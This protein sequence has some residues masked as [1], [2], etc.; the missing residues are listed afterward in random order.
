MNM[1]IGGLEL[2]E[3]DDL[4]EI[5]NKLMEAKRMPANA[6]YFA[7]TATPKSRTEELFGVEI[8][9]GSDHESA[10]PEKTVYRPFDSYTMKQAIQEGFIKD[11]LKN[12]TPVESYYKLIKSVDDDPLFDTEKAQKKLRRYVEGHERSIRAKAEVMLEHFDRQVYRRRLIGGDAR[13]MVVTDGVNRALEY[14]KA[15]NALI[16]QR[17]HPYKPIVAFSGARSFDGAQVTEA[18]LN[19]FP[20][21]SI[22]DRFREDPYR[23][24][25]VADKFQTGFD[26]PLLVAMYVDKV[27]SDVKAVQTLS[28]LNRAH[29]EK[30]DVF[31]LDFANTTEAIRKSFEKYYRTTILSGATDRNKLHDLK[32]ALDA[33][34]IYTEEEIE[35]VVERFLGG[36]DRG[37]LDPI[38]DVCVG[39]YREN[40]DEDE[41]VKFKGRAR[42]FLRAYHFLSSILAF[43][44]V[45]W[46]KSVIFLDLLV[47]KLPAPEEE[48]LTKGLLESVDLDTYR[49]DKKKTIALILADAEG[50][51]EP[52]AGGGGGGLHDPDLDPLSAIVE[53][54]NE[55]FGGLG[56]ANPEAVAKT[57]TEDIP[58]EV[59]QDEAVQNAIKQNERDKTRVEIDR[60][61]TRAVVTR[62]SDNLQLFKHYQDNPEFNR[63]VRG[64]V[65]SLSLQAEPGGA[66]E[67]EWSDA[68]ELLEEPWRPLARELAAAGVAPPS[69]VESEL[70]RGGVATE[71]RN[72]MTWSR[73][74]GAIS[75]VAEGTAAYEVDGQILVVSPEIDAEE[76]AGRL[77]KML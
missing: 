52:A 24:L 28:R 22:P 54:F 74:E 3:E 62:L 2:A 25:I 10:D 75:L 12:Y 69:D 6:S 16:A 21:S 26:E 43:K 11:V 34:Q 50:T 60:A 72:V 29:P 41:Q 39:R 18:S 13:A 9:P 17:G 4:E 73:P 48:D 70:T 31:V 8:P 20:S 36:A 68:L 42:A 45:D 56:W 32:A 5:L 58:A 7:F 30:G 64:T 33:E 37:T 47:P 67:T 51:L 23:I 63:W 38:L 14:F 49:N 65:Q 71:Q 55:L 59:L 76:L 15:F 61:I 44:R 1:V 77:V 53:T 46:E 35:A 57:I 66:A 27:L 40:L 19:G